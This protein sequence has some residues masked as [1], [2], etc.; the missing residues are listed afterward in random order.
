MFYVI[1][2]GAGAHWT[3][4]NDTS[5][6]TVAVLGKMMDNITTAIFDGTR[7]CEFVVEEEFTVHTRVPKLNR[8][9]SFNLADPEKYHVLMATGDM[10]DDTTLTHHA[11]RWVSEGYVDF[12][13]VEDSG[14][15]NR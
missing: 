15:T 1:S 5:R 6:G 4:V 3:V 2:V 12:R 10:K 8:E 9:V 7:V 11:D 13:S 14:K